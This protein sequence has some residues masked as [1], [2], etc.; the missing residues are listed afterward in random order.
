MRNEAGRLTSE[1]MGQK[2]HVSASELRFVL[3]NLWR[4]T[5]HRMTRRSDYLDFVMRSLTTD[6]S[7]ALHALKIH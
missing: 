6:P 1:C 5:F 2:V 3:S 4:V 7:D